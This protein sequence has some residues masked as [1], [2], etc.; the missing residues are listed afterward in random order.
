M[1]R[2]GTMMLL[3]GC[4]FACEET[5]EIPNSAPSASFSSMEGAG[6]VLEIYYYLNDA[7]G[8]DVSVSFSVCAAGQCFSPTSSPGGDGTSHLPTIVGAPVLHLFRWDVNCDLTN[9]LDFTNQ[10]TIFLTPQDED[11]GPQAESDA[12][13]VADYGISLDSTACGAE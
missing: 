12:F 6:T 9:E 4:L 13:A 1:K 8:D 3:F 5:I 11:R 7:E 2:V 10:R